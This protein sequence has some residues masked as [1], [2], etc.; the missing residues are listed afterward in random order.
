MI[1]LLAVDKP[2]GPTSHD[3]VARARHALKIRRVG[4]T[5]TLDPFASG[6]LV[7][8]LGTATR[9]AE[10]VTP[11]PKRYR[12]RLRL[13]EATATDDRTGVPVGERADARTLDGA[14]IS[15][16]FAAQVG[17]FP[18]QPPTYSAKK[19]RGRRMYA[20]ARRGEDPGEQPPAPEVTVHSIDLLDIQ[21]PEVIFE[22]RCGSG[23]YIRAIARDVGRALRVGGHLRELR[24]LSV[25][26]FSVDGALDPDALDPERARAALHPP[27]SAVAHLAAVRL[28]A[29]AASAV[30]HGRAVEAC[31]DVEAGGPVALLDPAGELLG[32]GECRAGLV[33]PR[34]ILA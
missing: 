21:L 19:I 14:E 12:A 18:Q 34:K 3:I 17:T 25:G 26:P 13:G 22:V 28:D 23:T 10:Y 16:A 5:G 2:E 33:H 32:I 27:V 24:R 11:L 31:T 9:L 6:L 7:L 29:A 4:H 30:R 15:A 20:V 1:G 8:C